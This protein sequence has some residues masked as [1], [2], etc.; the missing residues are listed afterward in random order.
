[1]ETT[2][3]IDILFVVPVLVFVI[4]MSWLMVTGG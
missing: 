4:G 1:M 2:E 3:I